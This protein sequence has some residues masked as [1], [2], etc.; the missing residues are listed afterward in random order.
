MLLYN[1]VSLSKVMTVRLA[2]PL[3]IEASSL[4]RRWAVGCSQESVLQVRERA[5]PMRLSR[6]PSCL[7]YTAQPCYLATQ[8][9]PPHPNPTTPISRPRHYQMVQCFLEMSLSSAWRFSGVFQ[10]SGRRWP[11]KKPSGSDSE[12]EEQVGQGLSSMGSPGVCGPSL[13]CRL[14][15]PLGV[16]RVSLGTAEG[17][18]AREVILSSEEARF[19]ATLGS[20]PSSPVPNP[21]EMPISEPPGP[22]ARGGP[23]LRAVSRPAPGCAVRATAAASLP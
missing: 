3:R 10:G 20:G 13:S 17:S 16:S 7:L 5:V 23:G 14:D 1:S 11:K 8:V 22:C 6:V 9:P 19:Q 4:W 12:E 15:A 18:A 21:S 2:Q